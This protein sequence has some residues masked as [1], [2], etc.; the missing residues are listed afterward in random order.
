M[1]NLNLL[2]DLTATPPSGDWRGQVLEALREGKALA[3]ET[4]I[5]AY[6]SDGQ[7]VVAIPSI[8]GVA[9]VPR[10]GQQYQW[11][12]VSRVTPA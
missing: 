12:T 10:G 4:N 11:A 7:P 6:M 3:V 9:I 2:V 8:P 5:V 1:D